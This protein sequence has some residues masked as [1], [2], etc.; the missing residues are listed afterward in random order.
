M[1]PVGSREN[2]FSRGPSPPP[3]SQ[4]FH[5]PAT[6]QPT[7]SH[8]TSPQSVRE[9]APTTHNAIESLFHNLTISAAPQVSSQ[10]PNV[11]SNVY[12]APQDIPHSGPATPASVNAGS[13][14]SSH[15]GPSNPV[16]DRQ[17]ALLSLLG[18]VASPPAN[19][20]PLGPTI[21]PIL[22]QQVPT[23]PG[24]APRAGSSGNESQTKLLLDQL[25]S[26]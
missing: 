24:S 3:Q 21:G 13:V 7:D 14:S 5:I 16:A 6:S 1:D 25:M 8:V 11:S 22:P 23:P 17:N 15:S 18:A 9:S 20:Q 12:A 19:T 10:P 26:G 4:Q 2:L